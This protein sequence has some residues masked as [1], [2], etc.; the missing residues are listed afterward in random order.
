[1]TLSGFPE[2]LCCQKNV[3]N[4]EQ[5]CLVENRESGRPSYQQEPMPHDRRKASA[6]AANNLTCCGMIVRPQSAHPLA[7]NM[8]DVRGPLVHFRDPF[9]N[10][11]NTASGVNG[12]QRDC[13]I[14]QHVLDFGFHSLFLGVLC[15][16]GAR[17]W[18]KVAGG[19]IC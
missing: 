13:E 12:P 6:K 10:I 4:T 11:S 9:H 18:G 14:F 1:M 3:G 5:G 19:S 15:L 2:E 16:W 7:C 17:L 8:Q